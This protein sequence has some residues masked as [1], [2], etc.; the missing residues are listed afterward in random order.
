MGLLVGSVEWETSV[1]PFLGPVFLHTQSSPFIAIDLVQFFLSESFIRLDHQ[2]MNA[3][4]KQLLD[5]N[6]RSVVICG[7]GSGLLLI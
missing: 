3:I 6:S 7:G 4:V 2:H 5:D 1:L